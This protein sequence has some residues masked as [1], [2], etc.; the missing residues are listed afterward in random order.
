MDIDDIAN[1]IFNGFQADVRQKLQAQLSCVKFKQLVATYWKPYTFPVQ[2]APQQPTITVVVTPTQ[3]AVDVMEVT[4]DNLH[5]LALAKAKTLAT[6]TPDS[7][8]PVSAPDV[9][10]LSKVR[11]PGNS[12][13]HIVL[14]VTVGYPEVTTALRS[15]VVG[16]TFSTSIAG[17][18]A[19][20]EVL[21]GTIYPSGG[22]L[23]V[24]LKIKASL[25]GKLLDTSGWVYLTG[26]PVVAAD[27]N[28]LVLDKVTF[29]R[30]LD[31]DLVIAGSFVF[32]DLIRAKV[33]EALTKALNL[34]QRKDHA[35]QALSD[36]VAAKAKGNGYALELANPKVRLNRVVVANS[37][38]VEPQVDTDLVIHTDLKALY[39]SMQTKH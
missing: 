5:I 16:K 2:V 39:T 6:T 4:D 32:Q 10:S 18:S 8:Y 13:M 11:R 7:S 1:K 12:A 35:L 30:Q 24:G 34:P 31:N 23:A 9:T 20:V 33:Q 3:L 29:A 36:T 15:Y 21:D 19:S 38:V 37:L 17:Q 14:P 25:P 28:T 27:G 26:Q 22:S